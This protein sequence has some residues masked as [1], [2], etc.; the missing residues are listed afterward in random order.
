MKEQFEIFALSLSPILEFLG[1]APLVLVVVELGAGV[2]LPAQPRRLLAGLCLVVGQHVGRVQPL[3]VVVEEAA[4]L[5]E[6]VEADHRVHLAVLD[7][8]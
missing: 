1:A 5:V 4:L 7:G 3:G 8:L 6:A 2:A